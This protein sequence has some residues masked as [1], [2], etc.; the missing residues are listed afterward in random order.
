[1]SLYC[2]EHSWLKH[3]TSDLKVTDP[4]PREPFSVTQRKRLLIKELLALILKCLL[5]VTNEIAQT[6]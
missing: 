1:M 5:L 3:G 4:T 2:A 6:F